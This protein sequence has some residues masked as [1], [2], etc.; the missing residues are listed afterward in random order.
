[1]VNRSFVAYY[2]NSTSLNRNIK[3]S[4]NIDHFSR[5]YFLFIT[6]FQPDNNTSKSN[7]S[8]PSGNSS[9]EFPQKSEDVA[10]RAWCRFDEH[11]QSGFQVSW[12]PSFFAV[13]NLQN[14]SLN[15]LKAL[16]RKVFQPVR[17][18]CLRLSSSIHS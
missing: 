8:E 10:E 3:R 6:S 7:S 16:M 1:M 17:Q 2:L 12:V 14:I 4:G 11:Y 13:T 15:R 5:F 18:A 9:D